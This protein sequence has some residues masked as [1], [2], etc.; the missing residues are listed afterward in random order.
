MRKIIG[1][2]FKKTK[3]D[4]DLYD[5]ITSHSNVSGFIKDILKR[6]MNKEIKRK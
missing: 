4:T 5:W 3:D 2:S 6:E 1:L